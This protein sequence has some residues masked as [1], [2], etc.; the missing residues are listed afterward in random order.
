VERRHQDRAAQNMVAIS[1]IEKQLGTT[2]SWLDWFVAAAPFSAIMSFVLYFV[3]MKM[4]PPETQEIAGRT[5]HR[6]KIA[7]RPWPDVA[8]REKSCSAF[9]W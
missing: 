7:G 9:R 8:Q 5:G 6:R 1:F 2:I 4:M 3:L